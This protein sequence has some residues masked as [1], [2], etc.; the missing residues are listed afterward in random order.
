M[1]PR[2]GS[3]TDERKRILQYCTE[4]FI[5]EG[6][7]RTTVDEIAQEIGISKNTIYKYFPSKEKLVWASIDFIIATNKKKINDVI[8]SEDNALLKLVKML[9]ILSRNLMRFTE[10][11]M[12]DMQYHAPQ[13]WEK[14]DAIRKRLMYQNLSKIIRQGQR[15]KVFKDYPAELIIMVF[16]SALR[17]VV[18]PQFLLTSHFSS[19]EA[20]RSTFEILLNGILTEKGKSVFKTINLPL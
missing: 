19:G 2:F 9:E 10:K 1:T 7:H 18:T 16:I 5:I 14:I 15:E 13:L 8:D 17:G 3:I 4:K 6:F 12:S 11:W 20:V